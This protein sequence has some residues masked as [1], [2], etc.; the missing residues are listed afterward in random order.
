MSQQNERGPRPPIDTR[1]DKDL[2]SLAAVT[3]RRLPTA[4][5]TARV[6][7]QV[8]DART[9]KKTY[10]GGGIME[11][12][13]KLR[14]RRGVTTVLGAVVVGAA[15]LVVPVPYRRTV[16]HEVTL[17]LDDSSEAQARL[18]SRELGRVLGADGVRLRAE[19]TPAGTHYAVVARTP[20][21]SRR[22]VERTTQALVQALGVRH[23]T[24]QAAINPK[25]EATSG[26]VYAMALDQVIQIRVDFTGKSD[27]QIAAE[28]RAQ[29]EQAGITTDE[30][31]FSREGDE[32]ELE[33]SGKD[34]DR[35][36]RL[37]QRRKGGEGGIQLDIGGIDDKREP[38]MTDEQ[39]R[40]KIER[41]LQERGLTGQVEING[42]EVRIKV[43]KQVEATP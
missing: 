21:R 15:L 10:E 39:L 42:D 38:G 22:Q 7:E 16:G 5:E 37:V 9:G 33:V 19:A 29:L 2:R 6:L 31:R 36:L 25:T 32:S 24:A 11:T 17:T 8:L 28:V 4:D 41:Q 3:A 13:R 40:E 27:E 30:V 23:I 35:Q 20:E 34:G 1:M 26:S 12:I 43:Q 14:A 18:V